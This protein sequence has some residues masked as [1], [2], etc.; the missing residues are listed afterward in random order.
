MTWKGVHEL[1]KGFYS[2]K[3]HSLLGVIPLGFFLLE[4]ML[5]NFSAVEGGSEGFKE[6]V[7]FLNS[8]PM[9]L[10][11]EMFGIW[12]PLLYHGV[13]GMY[14]AFQAKPNNNR[15]RNERNLRYLLQRISGVLVFAFVI[16]HVYET[17]VQVALGN[18]THEELGG[19]MH[20]IVTQPVYFTL[21]LIGVISAAFHFA[22]GLWSFLV[23]WGITVGPRA[24]RVSS[25]I[26][27]GMFVI[28]AVLFV[29]SLFAF[30]GAEFQAEGTA[31]LDAVR[32]L[33]G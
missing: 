20:G 5:T 16:W 10:A 2:R 18:V 4:H 3:L 33:A 31:L 27:M 26:C 6:S 13:Y 30:R 25:N 29:W 23:S 15:F 19:V 1:M 24:Q 9:V 22:N 7:A 14:I 17:R 12:L 28:V 21:Y 32:T 11:L 8:L